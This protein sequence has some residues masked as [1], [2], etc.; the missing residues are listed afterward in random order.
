MQFLDKRGKQ[1]GIPRYYKNKRLLGTVPVVTTPPPVIVENP[2]RMRGAR[3]NGVRNDVIMSDESR[4]SI[5]DDY[6]PNNPNNTP[7]NLCPT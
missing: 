1:V 7:Q 3:Q 6:N 2:D 4:S 5:Q